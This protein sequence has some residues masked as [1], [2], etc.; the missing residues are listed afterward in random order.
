MISTIRK[1]IWGGIFIAV[2]AIIF[3]SLYPN[4]LGALLFSMGLLSIFLLGFKLFTGAVT[5]LDK[6]NWHEIGL[7]LISNLVGCVLLFML[8]PNEIAKQ[9]VQNKASALPLIIFVRSMLCGVM[10]SSSVLCYKKNVTW[11]AMIYVMVFILAGFDHSIA[12]A[13][14]I[15]SARDFTWS[16][17]KLFLISVAGNTVGSVI[18][19]RTGAKK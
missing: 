9:I 12:N 13:C 3:L 1:S 19:Y 2:G 17:L 11:M 4:P 10:I 16:A 15:I 6:T 14:F 5:Y 18:F 8:P 7:I